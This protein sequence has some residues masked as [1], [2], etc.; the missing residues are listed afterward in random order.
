MLK[1]EIVTLEVPVLLSD[2][3][4]VV[5]PPTVSLPKFK[6]ELDAISDF[7]EPEPEPLTGTDSTNVLLMFFNVKVPEKVPEEVEEKVPEEV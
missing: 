2:T 5:L 6:V 1:P 4:S 3:A 7:E